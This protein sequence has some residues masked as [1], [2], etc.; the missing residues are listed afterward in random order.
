MPEK[1]FNPLRQ[2]DTFPP[3]LL[4]WMRLGW[5]DIKSRYRRTVFGPFW[6]VLNTALSILFL[7][8]IYHSIFHIPLRDFLPYI[9]AGI[10]IWNLIAANTAESCSAF[11]SLKF[12][13]QGIPIRQELI[14]MR[15]VCRN[16]IVFF[17]NLLVL[18]VVLAFFRVRISLNIF[19]VIPGM[20]V[21]LV[22]QA[23]SGIIL[24]YLCARFRDLSQLVT[25]LLAIIFLVTPVI[26]PESLLGDRQALA[27][28]NPLTHFISI[29]RE[30]L[31]S[32]PP[33]LF[34]WGVVMSVSVLLTFLAFLITRRFR[35]RLIYWL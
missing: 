27:L 23:T 18:A 20:I 21:I 17:H 28:Y 11:I 3:Q 26:W 7:G 9:A 1:T 22:S 31:L 29:I 24:A 12:L 4:N 10:I 8:I 35:R 33:S 5:R 34:S 32:R 16:A 15:L 13:L 25:S 30:P 6:I 2:T 14:I 19:L